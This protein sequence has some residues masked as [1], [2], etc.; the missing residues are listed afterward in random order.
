MG[1]KKLDTSFPEP[2]KPAKKG[3]KI[4]GVYCGSEK[5]PYED[6][7]SGFFISYQIRVGDKMHS[8]AG[9]GLARAMVRVP[10]GAKI[11]VTYEGQSKTKKGRTMTDF[12]VDVDDS[13]KLL[14]VG[15]AANFDPATG[16]LI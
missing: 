2:W 10:H 4:E 13:V 11:R 14:D 9:A 8:F 12:T 3:D 6:N 15:A 7:P 16:E 5:V 1:Y